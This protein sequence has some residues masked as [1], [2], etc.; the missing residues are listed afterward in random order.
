MG[1]NRSVPIYAG[2]EY[3]VPGERH[4]SGHA[5]TGVYRIQNQGLQA[6]RQSYGGHGGGIHL[7]VAWGQDGVGHHHINRREATARANAPVQA[8][9]LVGGRGG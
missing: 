7:S 1:V 6:C 9:A 8:D 3:V 2:V 5:L 4:H